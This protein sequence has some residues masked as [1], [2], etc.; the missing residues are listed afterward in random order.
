MGVDIKNKHRKQKLNI[1]RFLIIYFVLTGLFFLFTFFEPV[2]K[3]FDVNNLYSKLIVFITHHI[4]NLFHI[5]SSYHGTIIT[6]PGVSLDVLFG[7]NGLEAV[8]IYSIAI[9][10]FPAAWKKKLI[11]IIVGFIII[12]VINIIRIVGLAY[13]AVNYREVFKILHIYIAQGLMIAIAL[14]TFFIYLN[15]ARR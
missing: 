13:A 1:W 12:Q 7:C 9:L 4:L 8:M 11:G 5:Q 10:A 14:G 6:L 3:K 2:Q 15:Y